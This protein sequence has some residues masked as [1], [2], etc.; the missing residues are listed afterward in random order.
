MGA[1]FQFCSSSR[2]PLPRINSAYLEEDKNIPDG[3][4]DFSDV[5]KDQFL[6]PLC[7]RIPEI[8]NVHSDNGYIELK[9][10][11]HGKIA[12]SIH[13]YYKALK[14]SLFTYYKTKCDACRKMQSSKGN[15]FSYCSICKAN[16]CDGCVTKYDIKEYRQHCERHLDVCFPVN[17]KN[18]RCIDHFREEIN[19]YCADCEENVCDKETT[20]RHRGHNKKN[21]FKIGEDIAKYKNIIIKKNKL[22]SDIIK[23]NQLILNSY[24][25]FQY[26][27]FH[28][29]SLINLGKSIE[30]ENKRDEQKIEFMISGLEKNIK[31]QKKAIEALHDDRYLLDLSGNEVK[32]SLRDRNLDEEG[33]KMI[34]QIQFI[35]LKEIDISK[36]GIKKIEI[37]NDMNLPHL[38]YLNIS[39]N[40]IFDIKPLKEINSKKLKEICLQGNEN[41]EDFSPLLESDFP[42]LER[43]RL[44]N[45]QFRKNSEVGKKLLLKYENKVFYEIK[46]LEELK[47]KYKNDNYNIEEDKQID[48]KHVLDLTGFNAGNIL[49]KELYICINPNIE[50]KILNLQNNN[51]NDA[52]LLSRIPLNKLEKLDLSLNKITNIKFLTEMKCNRLKYIYLNDNRLTDISP[53][54]QMNDQNLYK[55]EDQVADNK[56]KLHFPKLEVISLKNNNIKGETKEIQ[57]IVRLFKGK[58]ITIDIKQEKNN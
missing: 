24:D 44:E 14:D 25:K 5:P 45:T 10:K 53:L 22:L 15:M 39:E 28:I 40:K 33:I 2:G 42:A 18:H 50:I 34:S 49:L 35:R 32:L 51:I 3:C 52:S 48:N 55:K 8:L 26:N 16:F 37:F 9:C 58:K 11:Y 54:I 4:E 7:E 43:L 29:Q 57:G 30:E 31:T 46:T 17:E 27:Y 36:N 6:C 19:T 13:D 20:T 12:I 21:L 47:Q 56:T 23:F 1:Q 38:E 41:I